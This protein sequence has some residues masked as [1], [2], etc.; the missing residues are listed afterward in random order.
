MEA[1]KKFAWTWEIKE[2]CLEEYVNMHLEPWQEVLEEHS[3]A[4][5]RNYSIFQNGAQFFYCFECDDVETAFAY[6]A[7]SEA[8]NRW[9]A[10]T[11]KMVKGSF[12]FNEAEP[13][14]PLREVFYLE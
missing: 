9:N 6:I 2:E 7:K 4:G 11:S 8:C 1:S 14:Q 5:I 12:D 13:I 3:K 10:I